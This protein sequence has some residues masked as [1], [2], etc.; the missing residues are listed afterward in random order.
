MLISPG[1]LV[2]CLRQVLHFCVVTTQEDDVV[3]IIPVRH[4]DV[5]PILNPRV[6]WTALT[7][8]FVD[9]VIEKGRGECTPL[10]N[11]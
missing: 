3:G 5:V 6:I 8:N 10:S 2:N 4:M 11:A 9:I 7:K 1:F